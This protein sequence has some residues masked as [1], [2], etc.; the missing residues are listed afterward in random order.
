MIAIEEETGY[1]CE[2]MTIDLASFASVSSFAEKFEQEVGRLDIFVSNAAIIPEDR[3]K[4]TRTA[5]GWEI[6]QVHF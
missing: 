4:A 5:D 3:S 2:V 1:K 6:T